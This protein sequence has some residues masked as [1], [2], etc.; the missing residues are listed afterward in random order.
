MKIRG[1]NTQV[2]FEA[3]ANSLFEAVQEAVQKGTNLEGIDLKNA[4]LSFGHFS[5][6]KMPHSTIQ[7]ANMYSTDF[8][9]ADLQFSSLNGTSFKAADLSHASFA[10]SDLTGASFIDANLTGVD[11]TDADLSEVNF[12][13]AKFKNTILDDGMVVSGTATQV[14]T[15]LYMITMLP[16]Y[17]YVGSKLFPVDLWWS[18]TDRI[19]REMCD[20]DVLQWW[21]VWRPRLQALYN[22]VYR[23]NNE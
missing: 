19:I 23:S 17:M 7:Q 1:W 22:Q 8:S 2:L 18:F 13:R 21:L 3:E 5:K 11:F 15:E 14:V 12:A 9:G 10:H 4:D 20:E 16:G 6:A